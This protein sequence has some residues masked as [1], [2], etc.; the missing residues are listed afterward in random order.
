MRPIG[1]LIHEHM[2]IFLALGAAEREAQFIRDTS[3]IHAAEIEKLI[4]FLRTT[5]WLTLNCCVLISIGRTTC[6]IQ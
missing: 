5:C 1:M 3:N 6:C 4:D 2:I